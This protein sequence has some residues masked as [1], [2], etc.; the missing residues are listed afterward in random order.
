MHSRRV[1]LQTGTATLSAIVA[2]NRAFSAATLRDQHRPIAA[3]VFDERIGACRDFADEAVRY[4]ADALGVRGDITELWYGDLQNRLQSAP[5][6]IAGLTREPAAY[7]LR[8]F[9]REIRYHEICRGDHIVKQHSVRHRVSAPASLKSL[10]QQLPNSPQAWAASVAQM[11]GQIDATS[12]TRSRTTIGQH[13]H[14]YSDDESRLVSWALAP[15]Y[16][17]RKQR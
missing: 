5:A 12:A 16:S 3:V 1:F 17:Q 9:A 14:A 6:M 8:S 10:A 11:M 7:Y 2:G 4:G 13:V 15:I